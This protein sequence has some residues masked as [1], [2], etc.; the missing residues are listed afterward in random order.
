M[1]VSRAQCLQQDNRTV[2]R[3]DEPKPKFSPMT[4]DFPGNHLSMFLHSPCTVYQAYFLLY[5]SLPNDA[6]QN[7]PKIFELSKDAMTWPCS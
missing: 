6:G 1:A 7:P 4:L 2:L 3:F 5:N